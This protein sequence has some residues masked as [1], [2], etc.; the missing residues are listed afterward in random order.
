MICYPNRFLFRGLA[1]TCAMAIAPGQSPLFGQSAAQIQSTGVQQE[2]FMSSGQLDSLVAPIALYPDS[3]VAQVLAASTYPLQIVTAE[4]WVQQNSGL[5]GKELVEAAG[6]QDWDPSIQAL[7]AFPTVLQM[8]DQSLEWTTAL[9]NAFLAQQTDVMA[10]IQ[11]MRMKAQQSGKLQSDTHQQVQTT[12]V[13][14][15]PA[16]VIQPADPEVIYVP[17]YEP[18]AVYGA[19]PEYYP[20]P[21]VAYPTGGV[22]AA[23]AISF[24]VGVAVG[25]IFN[26]CCGG[27][28]GWGWGA[29]WGPHA[30]LYV[31]NNFFNHNSNAFVNRG[32][33]GNAYRGGGRAGW[34][35][36]PRYRSAVPYANRSVANRYNGG[37]P[38]SM[39][40]AQRPANVANI[41]PPGSQGGAN[42]LPGNAG[43]RP[44]GR[45]GASQLPANVGANRPRG[46][47]AA[48]RP[49]N[50]AQRP[51]N[52]G[53][54]RSAGG[55]S[56][57]N[58]SR[59]QSNRGGAFQGGS[60][61]RARSSGNRGS[62]SMGGGRSRGGG[63][64]GR[65]GGGRRR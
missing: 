5:K 47:S 60:A 22:L 40:P 58:G 6:R 61:A 62:R 3:L 63:G 39:R 30:S 44:G 36:N 4:R 42:R 35:H 45:G 7:V 11:R 65:R 55:R 50:A 53:A 19:A 8:L 27:G 52:P 41:R 57:W 16:I 14:G 32:N 23:S 46:P 9:G 1:L 15:Q 26:G 31:N 48:Q 25:A 20:Y 49:A 10:A 56:G 51:A 2:K 64:G 37:R 34:N 43:A 21:A 18:A 24:G 28:W 13:E 59:G 54:N 29:N 38:G 12:T 17:S 33:W